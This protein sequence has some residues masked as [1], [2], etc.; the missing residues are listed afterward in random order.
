MLISNV[1][2]QLVGRPNNRLGIVLI[3]RAKVCLFIEW[4]RGYRRE[5]S[6][7]IDVAF[8]PAGLRPVRL[9]VAVDVLRASS[10]IVAALDA[11]YRRV[12][13]TASRGDAERLRAPGRLLAGERGC[14]PIEG[15]DLGNSPSSL[16]PADGED[17]VLCTTNGTPA[18]LSALRVAEVVLV[19]SLTNLDAIAER[20]PRGEQ[21]TIVCAGTDG[22]FALEDAYVAGRIVARLEGVRTDAAQAA[23]RLAGAYI[24]P[25]DPLAQ[26]A[27]A[28]VLRAT[29][30]AADI[31]FCA[32]ESVSTAV[33][34]AA[35]LPGQVAHIDIPLRKSAE[36]FL[37][38]FALPR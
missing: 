9:A 33:P 13:C 23:E 3:K 4:F 34:E 37:E 29:G 31:E 32:R 22:C 18:I 2:L 30:Q 15:F 19:G 36:S 8:T 24:N 27:N 17:L 1:A 16:P 21:T 7:T 35:L 10:T 6:G 20:I 38:G 11:G 26:S 12:L 28:A 14:Q 25:Y 5:M